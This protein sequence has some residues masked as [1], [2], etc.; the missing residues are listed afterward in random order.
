MEVPL[1]PVEDNIIFKAI[2]QRTEKQDK[3]DIEDIRCMTKNE[4]VDVEYLRKMVSKYH[5]EKRV[6]P[7]LVRLGIL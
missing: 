5:D 2:L 7:L 3:H 6:E 4:K 1:I